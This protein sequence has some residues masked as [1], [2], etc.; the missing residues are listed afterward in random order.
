MKRE[1][2]QLGEFCRGFH[3]FRLGLFIEMKAI[4]HMALRLTRGNTAISRKVLWVVL[5][6]LFFK[7][8]LKNCT[9]GHGRLFASAKE[10]KKK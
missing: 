7:E 5:S 1:N 6:S 3:K 2:E 8:I 9:R 4:T 10:N